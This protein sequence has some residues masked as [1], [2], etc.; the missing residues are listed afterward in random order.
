MKL[1]EKFIMN[2]IVL[3]LRAIQNKG[4]FTPNAFEFYVVST[5]I[6]VITLVIQCGEQS[7]P[8]KSARENAF[9]VNVSL[10]KCTHRRSQCSPRHF[11]GKAIG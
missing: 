2:K 11:L 9:D 1:Q 6:Y 4:A 10:G 8:G 5:G 3:P 7:K